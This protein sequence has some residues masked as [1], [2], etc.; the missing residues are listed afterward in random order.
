MICSCKSISTTFF[1][2]FAGQNRRLCSFP[3]LLRVSIIAA[4]PFFPV[5]AHAYNKFLPD[6][7]DL[8]AVPWNV[9]RKPPNVWWIH[10]IYIYTHMDYIY[11]PMDSIWIWIRIGQIQGFPRRSSTLARRHHGLLQHLAEQSH[12]RGLA[13]EIIALRRGIIPK[14]CVVVMW[15]LFHKKIL[16]HLMVLFN[17]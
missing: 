7:Y 10:I 4:Q 9:Y 2:L 17:D 15:E 14:K 6:F 16:Y 12:W 11:L 13:P 1:P 8:F 3:C 5:D